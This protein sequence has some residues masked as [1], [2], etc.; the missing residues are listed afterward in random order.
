MFGVSEAYDS[1]QLLK[2]SQGRFLQYVDV[3]RK[4]QVCVVGTYVVDNYLDG[5]AMGKVIKING[6]AF[7]VIGVMEQ[8]GD[9]TERSEDNNIFLPYTCG[10][11]INGTNYVDNYGVNAPARKILRR[12]GKLLRL[13]WRKSWRTTTAFIMWKA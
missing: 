10:L 9:N 11:K 1:L 8:Q 2:M 3:V 13:C 12:R 6:E 7:T 4:E 5:D